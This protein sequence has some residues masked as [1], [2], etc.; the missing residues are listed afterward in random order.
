MENRDQDSYYFPK[1]EWEIRDFNY[2]GFI[3]D[4]GGGGE[5]VIGQLKGSDVIAIDFRKEELLE[6]AEGPL[7]II[8]DARELKFLDE[9]FNTA[10]AFFSLMYVR[11][12]EDQLKVFQEIW[13]VLKPGGIFH[14]WDV[15][16]SQI[17][18][19]NTKYFIVHLLY[20]IG[21][22]VTE[23]G[24][25]MVWPSEPRGIDHYQALA[26]KVGFVPNEP[27]WKGNTFYLVLEKNRKQ[28]LST[29]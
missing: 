21:N 16:L 18:E 10:T 8:M 15:D 29:E 5:G 11:K 22:Q 3:L 1:V 7:K 6:A 14:L 2:E 12:P 19:T 13:R 23:T 20:R 17:P 4:V 26:D 9:T 24:Y 27:V 25:G 28:S